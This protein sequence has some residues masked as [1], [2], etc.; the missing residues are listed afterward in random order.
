MN[1]FFVQEVSISPSALK[2]LDIPIRH[3]VFPRTRDLHEQKIIPKSVNPSRFI[4]KPVQFLLCIN[5][6]YENASNRQVVMDITEE[7]LPIGEG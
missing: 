2:D 6:K 4:N 3:R 7:S 5:I 1:V